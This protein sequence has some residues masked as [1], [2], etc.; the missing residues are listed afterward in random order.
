MLVRCEWCG[1]EF[2]A[3]TKRARFCGGTCRKEYWRA[4]R[5]GTRVRL[6]SG[7]VPEPPANLTDA[8]IAGAVVQIRGGAATLDA[9]SLKGPAWRRAACACAADLVL[10][11][12]EE[13]G[14]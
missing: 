2:E 12:L 7:A 4:K 3:P 9:A 14:L 1:R 13:A 5:S 10:R 11:G 6:P 8:D